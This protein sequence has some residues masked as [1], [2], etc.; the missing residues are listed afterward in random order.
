[1]ETD[2]P[3]GDAAPVEVNSFHEQAIERLAP[4]LRV[5]ARA[6]DG[7]IE[8]VSGRR[9]SFLVGVQWHPESPERRQTPLNRFLWTRFREAVERFAFAKAARE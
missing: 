3:G 2:R 7:T 1:M 9:A 8:A 5:E 4:S 6:P